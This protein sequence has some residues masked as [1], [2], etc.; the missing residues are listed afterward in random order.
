[1]PIRN[2]LLA[3]ALG[4]FAMLAG[5]GGGSNPTLQSITVDSV[6]TSLSGTIV[7]A[8]GHYSDDTTKANIPVAWFTTAAGLDPPGGQTWGYTLSSG[9]FDAIAPAPCGNGSKMTVVAYAPANPNASSRGTMSLQT[10]I[11]L[12][13]DHTTPS[14]DGFVAGTL[15]LPC[16]N[17]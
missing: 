4:T 3:M 16:I 2:C 8:T 10:F 5:C 11:T 12:V 14:E 9:S 15:Q 6:A 1:M 7:T 13:F 17:N